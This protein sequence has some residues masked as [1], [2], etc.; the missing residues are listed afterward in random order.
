[1]S[2]EFKESFVPPALFRAF[3]DTSVSFDP[4]ISAG[5]L[6]RAT[7]GSVSV[8]PSKRLG[9]MTRGRP[10]AEKDLRTRPYLSGARMSAVVVP[11][12]RELTLFHRLSVPAPHVLLPSQSG[13]LIPPRVGQNQILGSR[14]NVIRSSKLTT[15]TRFTPSDNY[16]F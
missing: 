2:Q 5:A 14:S 1:M 9:Y 11:S 13:L 6:A 16:C 3:T 15:W 8:L 12:L 10:P 7:R 4:P